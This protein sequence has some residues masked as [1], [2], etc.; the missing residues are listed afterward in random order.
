MAAIVR[1]VHQVNGTTK[2]VAQKNRN[3]SIA[4]LEG[5]QRQSDQI[6]KTIVLG[7]LKVDI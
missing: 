6:R 4:I 7:V 1:P 3:A 5:T 2:Q